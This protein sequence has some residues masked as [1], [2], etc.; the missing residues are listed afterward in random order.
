MGLEFA[1]LVWKKAYNTVGIYKEAIH[2]HLFFVVVTAIR[3]VGEF[4]IMKD[5]SVPISGIMDLS[6]PKLWRQGAGV[7]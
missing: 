5:H 1:L 6:A 7:I 3:T 2:N 4:A